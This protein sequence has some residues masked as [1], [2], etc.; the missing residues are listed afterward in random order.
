M[1]YRSLSEGQ[2]SRVALSVFLSLYQMHTMRNSYKSQFV[3]FDE[4]IHSLDASGLRS[5]QSWL[6]AF[7]ECEGT[8]TFLITHDVGLQGIPDA[9]YIDVTQTVTGGTIYKIRN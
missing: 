7:S 1:S 5:I 4:A 6:K 3:F 2:K 9:D 8:E